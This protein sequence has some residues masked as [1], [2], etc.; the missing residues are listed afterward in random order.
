MKLDSTCF[1]SSFHSSD[2]I[3]YRDKVIS[4]ST[5]NLL[6]VGLLNYGLR[7]QSPD[8]RLIIVM[9]RLLISEDRPNM[10]GPKPQLL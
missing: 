7:I 2:K 3:L 4:T 1:S 6:I 10:D 9:A 8:S 5:I